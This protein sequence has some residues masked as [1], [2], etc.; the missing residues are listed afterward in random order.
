LAFCTE[1]GSKGTVVCLNEPNSRPVQIFP[2]RGQ[3]VWSPDG[4]SLVVTVPAPAQAEYR[5]EEFWG[6]ESAKWEL[7]A[8]GSKPRLFRF[9][10]P[11]EGSIVIMEAIAEQRIKIIQESHSWVSPA[12]TWTP[13]DTPMRRDERLLQ[14]EGGKG[15]QNRK[16]SSR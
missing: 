14:A 3:P 10:M 12:E 4:K 6:C 1:R 8:D 11:W 9:T 7:G 16:V 5:G 15:T 2:K 13:R